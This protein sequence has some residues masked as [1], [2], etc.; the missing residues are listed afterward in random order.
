MRRSGEYDA[1]GPWTDVVRT[2][3][4][5]PRLYGQA[6]IDPA[7]YRLVLK[8]PRDIERRNATPDMNLYDF[9]LAVEHDGLTVLQRQEALGGD[10]Y[11][12]VRIPSQQI[13]ALSDSV[14]L[15]DGQLEIHTYGGSTTIGYNATDPLPMQR[16]VRLLR[17]MYLPAA[18]HPPGRAGS[19]APVDLGGRDLNLVGACQKVLRSAPQMRLVTAAQQQRTVPVGGWARRIVHRLRP[20]VLHASIVLADE[21][22]IALLHRRDRTGRGKADAHSVACTFLPRHRITD[23]HV[24]PHEKYRHIEVITVITGGSAIS[25][26]V[27]AG[28]TAEALLGLC[29]GDC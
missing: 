25:F 17:R 18:A 6:G 21:R 12:R 29:A 9:L 28:E 13:T 8:V 20:S 10:T 22:E 4:E 7:E 16:L 2:C 15:L 1:F 24:Q 27:R 23:V 14:N 11:T 5:L 26:P 3:E 19:L